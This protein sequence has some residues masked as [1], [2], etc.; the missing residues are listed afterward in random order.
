MPTIPL[1]DEPSL[2]QLRNQAR[3]LQRALAAGQGA[4]LALAAEHHPAGP[5]APSSLSAAQ[6]IVA[7]Q[8]GLASWPR[9]R[10][11]VETVHRYSRF[12]ARMDAA[13][14]GDSEADAFLRLACL[15]YE[16]TGPEQWRQAGQLLRDRPGLTRGSAPA[17]AA[18]A[19]TGELAAILAA[20]PGAARREAGPYRWEPL[21]YLAYARH[22]PDISRDA[23]LGTARLLLTAGADPNAG[24][25][26]HGLPTPFTVLTGV[27]G[28][29]ERGPERQPRHPHA[30]ALAR[31]LLAAGAHPND[32]QALYNR[33]FEPG[34]DHLELLL[35]FGLGTGDGGPWRRRLGAAAGTGTPD[36]E[37]RGQLGWAIAHGMAGRV[38]LLAEHGA[39]IT[40]PGDD[41][42][43]PAEFAATTGHPDIAAYLVSKGAPAPALDPRA[44]FTAAALAGDAGQARRLEANHPG[45]AAEVR[46]ERPSLIVWAAAEGRPGAVEILAAA[47][48]DVN[49]RGRTDVPSD[50]EWQTALH[51]AAQAGD[52]ALARTLLALGADPDIRDHRFGGTPLGWARHFSQDEVADLLEPVTAPGE[53]APPTRT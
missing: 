33:M 44:A 26:W 9:L 30:Q 47:G 53:T 12:P 37:I 2:E 27:F 32:G 6:L 40:T 35:E 11:H 23:V 38:R 5:R 51:A 39:D 29:G 43:S 24:Y 8:Y 50:T 14:A 36:E 46:Q 28:E 52:V 45:L 19:D 42:V 20:D 7:R 25:L 21:F 18:A 4:A 1:P 13:A 16:D 34:D 3:E 48:W 15:T 49:V 22:D 31:L 41:G 17:A 10:Q